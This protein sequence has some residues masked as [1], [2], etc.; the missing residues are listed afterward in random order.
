[1]SYYTESLKPQSEKITLVTAESVERLKLFT[2]S[3]GDYYRVVNYFIV[4]VKKAGV[5]LSVGTL[6]LSA[7]QYYFDAKNKKLWV[8]V[9]AAI[10][11]KTVDLSV[12]YRHFFS[13]APVILPYDLNTGEAVEWLPLISS[14]GAIG[15][16]LDEENVGIV[17]ESSSSV[18]FI[19]RGKYFDD[20]FDTLIWENQAVKIYSWFPT[21][22]I[23]AK[24]TLFDGVI[25]SKGYSDTSVVF[26][27][28]DFV[29][30]LQNTLNLG[31]FMAS[32]GIMLPSII[33]TP[34]RRIYGQVD[35]CQ[36]IS[37]D[38]TLSGFTL[39]GLISGAIGA[40]T[41]T[42][43]G[44]I[45]LSEVSINDEIWCTVNGILTKLGVQ[46]VESNT[47]L[48][49]GSA[50]VALISSLPATNKPDI[51][52][53]LKNRSWHIAGHKL[54]APSTTISSVNFANVFTVADTSDFFTGDAITVNGIG[55]TVRRISNS[56]IITEASIA[57]A[58]VAT[59]L[60]VKQPISGV[61]FGPKLLYI[62]RDYTITNSTYAMITLDPLA[63][64]N[65]SQQIT[66]INTFTFTNASRIV[67]TAAA[68][69]LRTTLKP[70]DWIRSATISE[71]TWYE[72]LEVQAQTILLRSAFTDATATKAAYYKNVEI[73]DENS[74]VTVD[75]VGMEYTSLWMKTASDAVRHLIL[76]DAG[77]SV[78]NE[79]A[80]AQAK[81][82]CSYI[83]SMVL[84]DTIGGASPLIRDVITKINDS[85]FGSLYGDSAQNIGY[86]VLNATRP[87]TASAI[88]DDD[89]ISFSVVSNQKIINQSKMNYRPYTDVY[90]GESAFKTYSFGSTFVDNY[91]G[92]VN[93]LEKTIYVY[94]DNK[95]AMLA[96]RQVLFR[97]LSNGTV[98]IKGKM[99]LAQVVV[100]DKI[101]LSLD[102]LFKRYSGRDRRK[103]GTVTGITRDGLNCEITVSDLGNLYNRILAIAPITTL[104]FSSASNDDKLLWAFILDINTETPDPTSEIGIGACLIG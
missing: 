37:L 104:A 79:S 22:A 95:A 44:T 74:L 2:L 50:I 97:S 23:T 103:L 34:K 21:I 29:F 46:S 101:Y 98:K 55:A 47:S 75:C 33:G 31:L 58:P 92:I 43:I 20:L 64:F 19:N 67:T 59:N 87:T 63:E 45:F 49:I 35:K 51:P 52:Y 68:V 10:D 85:I 91:I 11:P 40:V 102:R 81:V 65:I 48:T 96:Q 66:A 3:G 69:D 77:F 89:I 26:N 16:Q 70:R 72:I 62:T 9:G 84:P 90:T 61:Y 88:Q 53:R 80:F 83:L 36:A 24:I 32:D 4:G 15:Q 28:K 12:T 5:S 17:L 86:S 39:T 57:P 27:V 13:N 38:A 7:N 100:N 14:I 8:N 30:K 6:P 60:I 71:S 93:L 99:N 18:T 42:G 1:M 94:E 25:E 41:V 56:Q 78:V 54:R 73:I 82:D 76:N